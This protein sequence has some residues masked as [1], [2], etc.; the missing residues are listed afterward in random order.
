MKL[1]VSALL[2]CMSHT[3]SSQI[4]WAIKA[5]AQMSGAGYKRDGSHISTDNIGGFNAGILAKIYFDDKVAFVSGLGYSSRGYKVPTLPG[6][7]VK[8]YRLNYAD[9]PVMIQIDLGRKRGEG[10]YC[11]F[12]PSI[13]I[14]I[15][16]K[17]NYTS[18]NGME[19]RN[20]AIL[21]LTG[22]HFGLFDAAANAA[23]GC[24]FSNKFFAEL[25]YAYGIGN[26]NNDP[27]GP[28]IKNRVASLSIGWFF[29]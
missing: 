20:K 3:A 4:H 12:G 16:G 17:E 21:S 22:N 13:G 14:G 25:N 26:I 27:N 24:T 19:V 7:T 8:T 11:K 2:L 6:D 28:N 9:L 23:I 29:N 15:S 1:I 10:M 18:A 5:G